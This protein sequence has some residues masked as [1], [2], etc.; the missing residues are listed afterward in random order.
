METLTQ[1]TPTP[2]TTDP[3]IGRE[4]YCEGARLKILA[5]G[6]NRANDGSWNW[7]LVLGVTG[8]LPSDDE[9]RNTIAGHEILNAINSSG[10]VRISPAG[11]GHP[12]HAYADEPW[13]QAFGEPV[14]LLIAQQRGGL[15]V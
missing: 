4:I 13:M 7:V 5:R 1:P 8:E 11:S 14:S 2:T 3:F 10:V 6:Q 15:D 9:D 12:G